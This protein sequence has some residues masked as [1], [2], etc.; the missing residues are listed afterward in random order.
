MIISKSFT[1]E[2]LLEVNQKFGWNRSENQLKN[3]EKAIVAL[4]LVEEMTKTPLI[5]I[6]KGGTSLLLLFGKILRFSVDVD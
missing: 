4:H 6:F 5:F 1:R 2:W 3:I